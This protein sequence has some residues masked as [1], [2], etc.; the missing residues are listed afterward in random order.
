MKGLD[1]LRVQAAP[2]QKAAHSEFL[3]EEIAT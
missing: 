2:L 3:G 1:L